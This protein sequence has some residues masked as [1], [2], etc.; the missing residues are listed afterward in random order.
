MDRSFSMGK[1]YPRIIRLH[2]FYLRG[3]NFREYFIIYYTTKFAETI[4]MLA[5]CL[6]MC[7]E[8]G[9]LSKIDIVFGLLVPSDYLLEKIDHMVAH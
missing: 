8:H 1:L 4:Y 2:R 5:L 3:A 9:E 7:N 6:K